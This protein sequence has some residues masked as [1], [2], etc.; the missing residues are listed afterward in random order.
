MANMKEQAGYVQSKRP[1]GCTHCELEGNGTAMTASH[2]HRRS[3]HNLARDLPEPTSFGSSSIHLGSGLL[4][5]EARAFRSCRLVS[6]PIYVAVWAKG[7]RFTL[8][9]QQSTSKCR[10]T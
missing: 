8:R 7:F 6:G 2:G 9:C 10:S 3:F 1:E 5:L 4:W